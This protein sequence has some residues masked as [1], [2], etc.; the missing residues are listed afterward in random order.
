VIHPL[1]DQNR[2]VACIA[3]AQVGL[4]WLLNRASRFSRIG[5]A[6]GRTIRKPATVR[7][8][9]EATYPQYFENFNKRLFTPGGFPRPL[10]ARERKWSTPNGKA[11]FTCPKTLSELGKEAADIYRGNGI[12][13]GPHQDLWAMGFR[14]LLPGESMASSASDN[15]KISR[16]SSKRVSRPNCFS[17]RHAI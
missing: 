7:E 9:I 17:G 16:F 15:L 14:H 2:G 10:P 8:A 13:R 11:N 6:P 1:G 4:L 12:G 5:P 3:R